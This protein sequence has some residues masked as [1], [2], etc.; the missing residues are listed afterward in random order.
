MR[1]GVVH[2]LAQTDVLLGNLLGLV[3][4]LLLVGLL[5]FLLLVEHLVHQVGVVFGVLKQ[6]LRLEVFHLTEQH[7]SHFFVGP[8]IFLQLHEI[9]LRLGPF[10]TEHVLD[11]V[12]LDFK[13]SLQE[14]IEGQAVEQRFLAD[15]PIFIDC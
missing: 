13:R 8:S 3:R 7:F 11:N 14:L 6:A 2:D 12:S 15:G 1:V 4:Y 9:V 10:I 5:L